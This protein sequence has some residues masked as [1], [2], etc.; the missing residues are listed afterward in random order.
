M[1]SH[2][3]GGKTEEKQQV[4]SFCLAVTG[5]KLRAFHRLSTYMFY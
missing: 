3:T 1:F 2:F 5:I 4:N